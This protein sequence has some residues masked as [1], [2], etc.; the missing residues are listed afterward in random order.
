MLSRPPCAPFHPLQEQWGVEEKLEP[1]LPQNRAASST[2]PQQHGL[3]QRV[4]MRSPNRVVS[5]AGLSPPSPPPHS[6]P[7]AASV[8]AD[9]SPERPPRRRCRWGILRAYWPGALACCL[10]TPWLIPPTA[11]RPRLA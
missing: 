3:G 6:R 4:P 2:S 10:F 11:P 9:Q 1:L 8:D 5:V 7:A